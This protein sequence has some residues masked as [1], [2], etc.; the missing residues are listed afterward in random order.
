M[1]NVR[2]LKGLYYL[3]LAIFK[4]KKFISEIIIPWSSALYTSLT[5]IV[6]RTLTGQTSPTITREIETLGTQ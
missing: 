3:K 4:M 5:L 2:I 6:Y 1:T